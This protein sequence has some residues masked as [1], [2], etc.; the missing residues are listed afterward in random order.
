[1]DSYFRLNGSE[2]QFCTKN[3]SKK[4]SIKFIQNTSFK[5]DGKKYG[6]FIE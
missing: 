4:K 5:N 3:C 1:M 6:L 2:K